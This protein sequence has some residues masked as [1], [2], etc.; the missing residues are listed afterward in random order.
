MAPNAA[1]VVPGHVRLLIDARAERRADME[2]F[3]SWLDQ[4]V[5]RRR[6]PS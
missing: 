1:N 6:A 4:A 2:T 3:A 5:A